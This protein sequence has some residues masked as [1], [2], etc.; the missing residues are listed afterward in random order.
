MIAGEDIFLRQTKQNLELSEPTSDLTNN[1]TTSTIPENSPTVTNNENSAI[2][3]E[4]NF[5]FGKAGI[6]G[7]R[8]Y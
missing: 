1:P 7:G 4:Q 6:G 8:I 2:T 3:R 5:V